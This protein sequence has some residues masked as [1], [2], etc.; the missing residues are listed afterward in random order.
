MTAKGSIDTDLD[1]N[2]LLS[3]DIYQQ[4]DVDGT[5]TFYVSKKV[6][7]TAD[8]TLRM[9]FAAEKTENTNSHLEHGAPVLTD[10]AGSYTITDVETETKTLTYKWTLTQVE[11]SAYSKMPEALK[12]FG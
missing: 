12:A 1:P 6:S 5:L 9:I 8:Y 7:S 10:A 11:K 2:A 3:V 4:L